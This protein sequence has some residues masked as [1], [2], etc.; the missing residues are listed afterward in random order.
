LA[1]LIYTGS[2]Q[3]RRKFTLFDQHSQQIA[4]LVCTWRWEIVTYCE[5]VCQNKRADLPGEGGGWLITCLSLRFWNQR[6]KKYFF[7]PGLKVD[8]A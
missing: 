4:Y 6:I 1:A 2:D 8:V 5:C 7:W 3:T